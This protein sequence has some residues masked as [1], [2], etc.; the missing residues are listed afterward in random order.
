[1]KKNII[2]DKKKIDFIVSGPYGLNRFYLSYEPY[3]YHD[4]D[5][6]AVYMTRRITDKIAELVI[7]KKIFGIH[8]HIPFMDISDEICNEMETM[9]L[10]WTEIAPK[11][12]D[13]ILKL[14]FKEASVVG[15]RK[16]IN[17]KKEIN[18]EEIM[19]FCPNCGQRILSDTVNECEFCKTGFSQADMIL[20]IKDAKKKIA[21][22][23]AVKFVE[24]NKTAFV[25]KCDRCGNII[26]QNWTRCPRCKKKFKSK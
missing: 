19:G 13:I 8:D 2:A 14:L 24:T 11:I 6:V 9:H 15:L 26:G 10:I 1:M 16:S 23:R 12:N 22:Y 21:Q 4:R 25:V 5:S 17:D 20:N 18:L 3:F 7:N